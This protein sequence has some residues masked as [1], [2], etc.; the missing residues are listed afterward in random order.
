M[1]NS[2]S[3]KVTPPL[4]FFFLGLGL[5]T[6]FCCFPSLLLEPRHRLPTQNGGGS[7][8]VPSRTQMA[9]KRVTTPTGRL[10]VSSPPRMCPVPPTPSHLLFLHL[11]ESLAS[12]F[13]KPIKGD[14]VSLT[15]AKSCPSWLAAFQGRQGFYVAKLPKNPL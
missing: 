1:S 12:S 9:P 14:E 5:R 15:E 10:Q 6:T 3:L 7:G 8:R 11:G 4:K 13:R 2:W